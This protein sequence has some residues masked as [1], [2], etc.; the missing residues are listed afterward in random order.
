MVTMLV[1]ATKKKNPPVLL[2][3]MDSLDSQSSFTALSFLFSTF[4]SLASH[5]Q[6]S[7]DVV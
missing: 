5:T 4:P 3:T 2:L 1:H 6:M 7:I